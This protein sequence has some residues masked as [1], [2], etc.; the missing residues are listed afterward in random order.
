MR[1]PYFGVDDEDA[2]LVGVFPLFLVN[3]GHG[4]TGDEED[5][6]TWWLAF[7]NV[8]VDA[9]GDLTGVVALAD[10]AKAMESVAESLETCL[11]QTST[12]R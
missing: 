9:N 8:T 4:T 6:T 11:L 3:A 1:H 7:E 2:S 12:K 5:K 10:F